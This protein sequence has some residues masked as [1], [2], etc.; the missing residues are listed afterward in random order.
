L[1]EITSNC[2]RVIESEAVAVDH[3]PYKSNT[4][5]VVELN[6]EVVVGEVAGIKVT[7][8]IAVNP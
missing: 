8:F 6:V 2:V 7:A 3:V 5:A 1:S 4:L